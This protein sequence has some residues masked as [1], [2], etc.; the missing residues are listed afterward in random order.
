MTTYSET[1][2]PPARRTPYVS[3][4]LTPTARDALRRLTLNL[5]AELGERL[6]MSLVLVA[7]LDVAGNHPAELSE[8]V[9]KTYTRA[10]P[11]GD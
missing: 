6:S 9:R 7:A 2:V 10:E 8:A 11:E 3:T 4:N 5:S 1:L